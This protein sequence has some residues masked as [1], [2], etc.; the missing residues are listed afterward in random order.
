M[1]SHN[2]DNFG[3]ML[4]HDIEHVGL[5]G[6]RTKRGRDA[7]LEARCDDWLKRRGLRVSG[8]REIINSSVKTH[9]L[10]K[11]VQPANFA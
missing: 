6:H 4:G 5:A 9:K 2:A 11:N 3:K 1:K 7:E 8:M 10:S